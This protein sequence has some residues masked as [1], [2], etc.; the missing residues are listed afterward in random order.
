MNNHDLFLVNE[1]LYSQITEKY[2]KIILI[3]NC[4]VL[5]LFTRKLSCFFTILPHV[6]LTGMNDSVADIESV[7]IEEE[8]DR[9]RVKE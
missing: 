3:W 9:E 1:D 2:H 7:M 6:D 8:G 4:I 5:S